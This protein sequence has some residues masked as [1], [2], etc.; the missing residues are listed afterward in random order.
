MNQKILALNVNNDLKFIYLFAFGLH[1][2]SISED[3]SV[4]KDE[5]LAYDAF[6]FSL[7]ILCEPSFPTLS[8]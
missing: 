4:S 3:L 8:N 1:A 2:L 7:F 5:T 6:S